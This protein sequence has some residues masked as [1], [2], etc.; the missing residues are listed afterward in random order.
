MPAL[1]SILY[2]EL[3]GEHRIILMLNQTGSGELGCT[4][5]QKHFPQKR[6][7]DWRGRAQEER[8]TIHRRGNF[9]AQN[10]RKSHE[11]SWEIN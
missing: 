8:A 2:I 3:L 7:I 6:T 9:A 11:S 4:R 1:V 10:F 5:A